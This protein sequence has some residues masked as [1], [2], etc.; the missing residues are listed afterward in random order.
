MCTNASRGY[1]GGMC[2]DRRNRERMCACLGSEAL[3]Q[4]GDSGAAEGQLVED[5]SH[6][7]EQGRDPRQRG[8]HVLQQRTVSGNSEESPSDGIGTWWEDGRREAERVG[9]HETKGFRIWR[10]DLFFIFFF[11]RKINPELTAA[12]PPLFA[13]EDW[14]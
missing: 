13:E 8:E 1:S 11:L 14:P 3:S 5:G 4:S 9:G 12:N 2:E 6:A 10:R 7:E